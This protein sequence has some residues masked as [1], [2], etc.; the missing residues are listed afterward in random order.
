MGHST[1]LIVA[2]C[3]TQHKA[4]HDIY[5]QITT[6]TSHKFISDVTVTVKLTSL[7]LNCTK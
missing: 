3:N 2:D 5:G 7:I 6:R 1:Q 4:L